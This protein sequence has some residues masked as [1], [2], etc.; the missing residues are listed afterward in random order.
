VNTDT[1]SRLKLLDINDYEPGY[2][3]EA[4]KKIKDITSGF[5]DNL[6]DDEILTFLRGQI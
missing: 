5:W 1:L 3:S 6:N 2:S 4:I